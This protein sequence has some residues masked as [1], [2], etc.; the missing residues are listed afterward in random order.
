MPRKLK[1]LP[2]PPLRGIIHVQA[3][4][5][6]REVLLFGDPTGLRSLAR[7]LDALAEIDQSQIVMPSGGKE[8]IHLAPEEHL[9]AFSS[10]LIVSRADFASGQLDDSVVAG[11][12]KRSRAIRE[13]REHKNA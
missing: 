12:P 10:R 6:S 9:D 4:A 13:H 5:H 11:R 1:R 2:I 3:D 8:H 7:V